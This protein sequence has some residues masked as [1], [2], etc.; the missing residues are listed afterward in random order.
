MLAA[1]PRQRP[2]AAALLF[3]QKPPQRCRP[4]GGQIGSGCEPVRARRDEECGG[5]LRGRQAERLQQRRGAGR[6]GDGEP[7]LVAWA[8]G[9]AE[10]VA[11]ACAQQ[12]RSLV[13]AAGAGPITWLLWLVTWLLVTWLL[14]LV[15]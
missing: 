15:T 5:E 1:L 8:E 11:G 9:V 2:A 12:L 14:W 10:R 3:C 13:L 6:A 7:G 4:E